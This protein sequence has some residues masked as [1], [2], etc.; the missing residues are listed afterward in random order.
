MGWKLPLL[1]S[2]PSSTS[3]TGLSSAAF[4]S[5]STAS[6]A[7]VRNVRSA[8]C[9]WGAT[10]N[11]SGSCTDVA[12]PG[13]Q[14]PLPV[15]NRR[16]R[17]AA[18]RCPGTGLDR[19]T[20][21]STMD[22]LPRTDSRLSANTT[23]TARARRVARSMTRAPRPMDTPFAEMSARPSLGP[24][25]TGANPA[26]RRASAPSRIS[27]RSSARPAPMSTCAM[28]AMCMRSAAPT[29]PVSPMTGW[30]PASSIATR[31]SATAGLIPEPPRAKPL[32][33]TAIAARTTSVGSGRPIAPT[34]LL[35]MT[36][37]YRPSVPRSTRTSRMWPRPV[38]SP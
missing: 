20:I 24:S 2:R 26:R 13:S 38:F 1:T 12:P 34:W 7:R 11:D 16:I 30:M 3:T 15:R 19:A 6:R 5:S 31:P 9:T 27:P 35:T 33:R 25:R 10:R 4:S 28:A 22:G 23:S 37:W 29:E 14:R 18:S 8:P 36:S 32:I 21:G 17:V